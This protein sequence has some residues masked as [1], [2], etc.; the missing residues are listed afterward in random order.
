MLIGIPPF[1]STDNK[2]MFRDIRSK[3]IPY[4]DYLSK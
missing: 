3:P 2:K 4:P 1:F